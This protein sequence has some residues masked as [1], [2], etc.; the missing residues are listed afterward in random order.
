MGRQCRANGRR[1]IAEK[2]NAQTSRSTGR[3][4]PKSR[5]VGGVEEGARKLRCRN[6]LMAGG[7][8]LGRGHGPARAVVLVMHIS[9]MYI[10]AGAL[11]LAGGVCFSGEKVN[12]GVFTNLAVFRF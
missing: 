5:W 2:D 3:G 6:W 7:I 9:C 8:C 12:N 4:R 10:N 11:P 1:R